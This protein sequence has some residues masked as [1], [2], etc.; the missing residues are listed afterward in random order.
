MSTT[1][2]DQARVE[3]FVGQIVQETGATL[4]RRWWCWWRPARALPGAGGG[5][6]TG[7]GR[8]ATGTDSATCASGWPPRRRSGYVATTPG[9]GATPPAE[10]ALA[11]VD[12]RRAP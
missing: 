9:P 6:A 2:L 7:G 8:R 4:A 12:P 3:Q 5:A 10:H 11:L 1:T